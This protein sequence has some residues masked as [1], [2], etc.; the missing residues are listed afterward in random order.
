MKWITH[1]ALAFFVVKVVEIA[2]MIDL[3]DD[4][5]AYA[6][7][8]VFAVIPDIDLIIGIKHRTW[9]HTLYASIIAV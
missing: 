7:V 3:L 2:L 9:T 4:Y 5:V 8:S 1:I 6:V